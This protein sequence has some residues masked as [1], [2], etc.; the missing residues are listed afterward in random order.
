VLHKSDVFHQ[1]QD[2]AHSE[3]KSGSIAVIIPVFKHSA[4]LFEAI[5]SVYE[6]CLSGHAHVVIVDDGCPHFQTIFASGLASTD[7]I[8]YIRKVNSGLS[9]ARNSGIDFVL[10]YLPDCKAIFFLDADNRLSSYSIARFQQ[11]T[12]NNPDYDWFYPD[13]NMIGIPWNG[14]YSGAFRFLTES[15]MNV[16]EAGSLVRRRVFEAGCR[17]DEKMHLGYEDWEFWLSLM[18][19]GFKALHMP[20]SGFLYRKRAESMVVESIRRHQEIMQYIET[21]HPWMR[22]IKTLVGLE[23]TE[24]PRFAVICFDSPIVLLGSDPTCF[25]EISFDDYRS[26]FH[27]SLK[28]PNCISSG[29]IVVFTSRDMIDKLEAVH[30]LRSTFWRAE[31]ELLGKN[32]SSVTICEN[33]NDTFSLNQEKSSNDVDFLF[34]DMS[35]VRKLLFE[36]KEDWSEEIFNYED[37]LSCS[38]LELSVDCTTKSLVSKQNQR[39]KLYEFVCN[40]RLKS[41]PQLWSGRSAG[42][43]QG[44][45]DLSELPKHLRG[46][47]KGGVLPCR[48]DKD[49]K[50]V[51]FVI[52]YAAFEDIKNNAFE[53]SAQFK[54]QGFKVDLVV[55]G[56]N[57]IGE[58]ESL[59]KVY[60]DIYLLD[61][62]IQN[63]S[64]VL[65]ENTA[66]PN[67]ENQH[68]EIGNLLLSYNVVINFCASGVLN[69]F[70]DL[71][72][73]KVATVN[74]LHGIEYN[75]QSRL[76]GQEVLALA[77]EHSTDLILCRSRDVATQISAFGIPREKTCY[78][79]GNLGRFVSLIEKMVFSRLSEK[80]KNNIFNIFDEKRR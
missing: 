34:A 13:I 75:S 8:H 20:A 70:A 35:F 19:R 56:Y 17:F 25:K 21:K 32:F 39:T 44:T 80:T 53:I 4:F 15:L 77:Y 69:Y 66:L 78:V 62:V 7:N 10:N 64:S 51:A 61:H 3:I 59:N 49:S 36:T 63:N 52:S 43:E 31:I 29:S 67:L 55:F 37:G 2:T 40:E 79:E 72:R 33:V 26:I 47:F 74:Y 68:A 6:A 18:D 27:G 24:S 41:P 42:L 28:K 30:I 50:S 1:K 46:K 12:G 73:S 57:K 16:C 48:G 65:F 60:D 22:D 14:N 54:Q 45:P 5:T 9:A 58:L 11:I 71:R 23:H 76:I 38:H